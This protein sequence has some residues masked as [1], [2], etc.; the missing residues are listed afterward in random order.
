M[1]TLFRNASSHAVTLA[2][3]RTLAPGED[4]EI[5]D[6]A[7]LDQAMVAAGDLIAVEAPPDDDFAQWVRD[8][9]VAEV[10]ERV[11]DDQDLRERALA[12]EGA[13]DKPR[14]TLLDQL[15]DTDQEDTP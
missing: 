5:D 7:R 10:L 12:A 15:S 13:A 1:S 8:S 3:G 4:A 11:G 14:K 6:K 2:S 9:K